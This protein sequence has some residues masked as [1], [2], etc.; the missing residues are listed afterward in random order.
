MRV[1][2]R[3]G[4]LAA[5]LT[6]AV[7]ANAASQ[8]RNQYYQAAFNCHG[9]LPAF[10]GMLRTRPLAVANEGNATAYVTCGLTMEMAGEVGVQAGSQA[11][12]V[13][14]TN[15]SATPATVGCTLVEG[16]GGTRTASRPKTI[17]IQ[18]GAYA[19][20]AWMHYENGGQHFRWPSLSCALP[21]GVEIN[22]TTQQF[23][24][25]VGA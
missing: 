1:W 20:L 19:E 3:F 15:R 12:Y 16:Y 6:S 5:A 24:E 8:L 21:A 23:Y 25:P 22:G 4:L 14:L 17:Q 11:V 2:I 10:E 7:S 13:L 9:A 18:P